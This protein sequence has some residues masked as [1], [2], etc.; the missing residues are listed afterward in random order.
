MCRNQ[1]FETQ[2][3]P[4]QKIELSI[5]L[6]RFPKFSGGKFSGAPI[7]WG[8]FSGGKFSG[9]NFPENNSLGKNNSRL[10][11][12]HFRAGYFSSVQN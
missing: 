7:S 6:E 10:K 12:H 8:F 1:K 2:T 11:F 9:E 5:S 4:K 3:Q